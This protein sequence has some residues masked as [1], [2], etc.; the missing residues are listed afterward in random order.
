MYVSKT[1]ESEYEAYVTDCQESGYTIEAETGEG[2]Y[3]A[4]DADGYMLRLNYLRSDEKM[5]IDLSAPMELSALQWPVGELAGMLPVPSSSV[6]S[7]DADS[8]DRL[9]VY[10][11]E[12]PKE[13]YASYVDACYAAG[14]SVDYNRGDSLFTAK[15]AQGFSLRVCYEG[16]SIMSVELTRPDDQPAS[17]PAAEEPHQQELSSAPADNTASDGLR[18]EFKQAMDSYEQFFDE[19]ISFMQRY[20]ASD[21]TDLGLLADYAGYMQKFSEMMDAMNAW[22][23]QDMNNAEA[24]YY[25]E[26]QSRINQKLL[27]VQ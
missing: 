17:A 26:V 5:Y 15:N 18:P 11:G 19:Y 21:G 1:S 14:F 13:V 10:V 9:F 16:N 4:Y 6:G 27:A 7:V 24:A 3:K 25:I 8:S 20:K 12:T 23:E 2:D 22:D